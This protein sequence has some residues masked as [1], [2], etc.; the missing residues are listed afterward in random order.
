MCCVG[1]SASNSNDPWASTALG[2][3]GDETLFASLPALYLLLDPTFTIVDATEAYAAQTL[4][5]RQALIGRFL[6]D[7]FPDNPQDPK[8]DGVSNL[9][10][11]LERVRRTRQPDR[12]AVQRYDVRAVESGRFEER[13][14]RPTNSPILA[15]DGTLRFIVHQVEDVT[16]LVALEQAH[17]QDG[18]NT[19]ALLDQARVTEEDLARRVAELAEARRRYDAARAH[20]ENASD[21][22]IIGT[23]AGTFTDVNDAA[24]RLYR[25]PRERL[26]G[27]IPEDLQ[28]P[29]ELHRVPALR[30]K[31]ARGETDVGVWE[32]V[33][34][35]GTTFFAEVST[36]ILP[37]GRWH[38]AIRDVTERQRA[39]AALAEAVRRLEREREVR[40]RLVSAITHDLRTPITAARLSA[41]ALLRRPDDVELRGRTAERIA[42]NMDRA[43]RMIRDLLDAS[44][45]RAGQGLSLDIGPGDAAE[46][47][48]AAVEELTA[49]YGARFVVTCDGTTAG[50][51]DVQALRRVVE[52][53]ASNA[54]KYGEPGSP[55]AISLD[56]RSEPEVITLRVH[57][58]GEPIPE[59]QR[60]Q[61]FEPFS[62][63]EAVARAKPGWG[64]GLA[65]V[66]GLV[67]AHGGTVGIESHA[68]AGTTFKIRL[69][70]D[71]RRPG[72]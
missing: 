30:E 52:N 15:P 11:S 2:A 28:A 16:P 48:D 22:L 35:D 56:A 57:N 20:F 72:G 65:I 26:L 43:D 54:A 8:A 53:L 3:G 44:R 12:M 7:A 31:M 70:R 32:Q 42:R 45:L 34:G 4:T 66:R 55:I 1:H 19:Q 64:I 59:A 61:L 17:Q 67:E 18:L 41:D 40:E 62:R 49:A 6:F 47:I 24:C 33:R 27:M 58:D 51:W 9:R 14:W 38:A 69:P 13:H 37:D 60:E 25:L 50:F 23:A 10:A 5:T 39:T 71:A 63:S 36:V 29:H 21:A 68:G 46:I